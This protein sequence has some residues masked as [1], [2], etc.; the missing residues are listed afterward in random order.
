MSWFFVDYQ[1]NTDHN[2]VRSPICHLWQILLASG[3]DP[4]VVG[5]WLIAP[6]KERENQSP[7]DL[8]DQDE[9]TSNLLL[10]MA[11]EDAA[12]WHMVWRQRVKGLFDRR[13]KR[14]NTLKRFG[15]KESL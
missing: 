5:Y 15:G 1:L 9:Q 3:V 12:R 7:I 4:W 10:C 2:Q 13:C 6:I 11:R 14:L 8:V